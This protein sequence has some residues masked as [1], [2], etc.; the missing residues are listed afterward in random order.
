[1]KI[2]VSAETYAH[3]IKR[4]RHKCQI[5][6]SK[7]RL[8]YHHILPRAYKELINDA[9]NGI[10]LCAEC[11]LGRAHKNMVYWIPKLQEIAKENEEKW[12]ELNG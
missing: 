6:G 8:Q 7:Q 5:C 3:V 4:D 11:H 1:M 10:M 2:K 9:S 12:K